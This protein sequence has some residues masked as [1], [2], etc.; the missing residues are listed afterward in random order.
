MPIVLSSFFS[1]VNDRDI[2]L[3]WITSSELNNT[4]FDVER[5][6]DPNAVNHNREKIG[7]VKGNGTVNTISLYN[8]EDKNLQAGKYR[9]RLK[10]IDY[11]S[12]YEYHYLN[13]DVEISAPK[14]YNVSQNYPNPFNPVTKIGYEIPVNSFVKLIIYDVLGKEVKT[15]VNE[16]MKPGIY[17]VM[18]GGTDYP[19]GVYFYRLSADSFTESKRMLI[20][21]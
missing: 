5:N 18:F 1:A 16:T 15:L 8:Y 11:N 19:S 9:Y 4:G 2:K 21:K 7:F 13:N 3:K 6:Q 14:K 12:N 20:V 10:Q 17:E